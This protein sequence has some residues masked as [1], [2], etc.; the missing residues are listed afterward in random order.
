MSNINLLTET[1]DL[2]YRKAK[3]CQEN[4]DK[5]LAKKYYLLASEQMLKMAKQSTGEL[6]KARFSRAKSLIAMAESIGVQKK[7]AEEERADVSVQNNE[8]IT[9]EEALSQLNGLIGLKTVKDQVSDWIDQIKV[10][11][12]RKE[13]GM[14]VPE[15]SYHMVFTGNPGTGKTTVARLIAQIYCALGILS[16]G[17]LVEVDRA[18]LVAGY[19]GQ[20]ATKTKDVLK[21]AEGGVLFIDEA[22]TLANGGMNDFGQE[23]IDTILKEMEDKRND[24]AIIVAGYTNPMQKFISSNPGLSSRF[25]NFIFFPDYNGEELFEIFE[26]FCAKNQYILSE[27]AKN[28]IRKYFSTL[29]ANRENNFGNARDVRNIFEETVTRQSKRISKLSSPT[30]EDILKITEQDFPDKVYEIELKN[31]KTSKPI[32]PKQV[33][34]KPEA[35]DDE[36]KFGSPE[37]KVLS[38]E[39]R[40]NDDFKFNWDSLPSIRFDDIA[41]LESVKEVVEV[42]VLLPLKNPKAFEG[43]VRKS[44]GGLL[45]YGPPGTGK[46]MIAAAIAN[47]IGAK[48]CSVKP[49]DLLNQGVGNS[50]KAV[51]ALFDQARRF[52]CAVVYFDEMDSISPKNTR[53]QIAK[54]LRSEFLA[55]IQGIEEYGK[56]TNN[57]LF[58]VAS[59]NKPWDIDSAFIRPGRF[60]TRIYVGLPDDDA[61]KYMI[62]HRLEKVKHKGVVSISSDFN[63]SAVVTKTNGYNGADMTNLMDRVEEISALRALKTEE[64]YICQ[65]DF[66]KAISEITPSVQKEDIEKLME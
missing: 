9:L 24:I 40:V 56:K 7:S 37:E 25:K 33:E 51:R 60:G 4:G 28:L 3:E 48:F 42:K 57:I 62:E 35:K 20:T 23:A 2:Y 50:E 47:E 32:E 52:P 15:M 36:R 1:F 43:Y 44:G 49:S 64:K 17:Q 63:V 22:Y 66:E 58:L 8:K 5:L 27:S 34:P 31:D 55:Q 61:R 54:Q 46:T 10:F 41:G 30:N 18:G 21:K 16:K 45:L 59:T 6:Q 11:Q 29:F 14:S 53:S 38:D 26:G 12:M 39:D 19:V 13:R 65:E